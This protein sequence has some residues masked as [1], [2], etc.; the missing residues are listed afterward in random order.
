MIS[1][2]KEQQMTSQYVSTLHDNGVAELV[3]D[4]PP[5]NALNAAGW[6]GLAAEIKALGANPA[7][8][9]IVIRAEGRGFCAGVDIKEL[10]ADQSL[11][12]SVNAGNYATF[13]A[14]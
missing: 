3:L 5:V 12:I 11:I 10:N 8:R 7:V 4:R 2:D 9:V 13:E 14:V 6:H 1:R